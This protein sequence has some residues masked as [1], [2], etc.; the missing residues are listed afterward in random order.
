MDPCITIAINGTKVIYNLVS[1]NNYVNNIS[2]GLKKV[3]ETN[4]KVFVDR[5][6]RQLDSFSKEENEIKKFMFLNNAKEDILSAIQIL[7]R[8]LENDIY[9]L[10][11]IWERDYRYQPNFLSAW[12]HRERYS[13]IVEITNCYNLLFSVLVLLQDN[14]ALNIYS[15]INMD[16]CSREIDKFSKKFIDEGW[17][18]NRFE[19]DMEEEKMGRAFID[20]ILILPVIIPKHNKY[21]YDEKKEIMEKARKLKSSFHSEILSYIEQKRVVFREKILVR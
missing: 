7:T 3:Y 1:T 11:D 21:S 5:A 8:N 9:P 17:Y 20:A 19:D 16:L 18:S 6:I 2:E 10:W 12:E 13:A 15:N 4:T 14:E